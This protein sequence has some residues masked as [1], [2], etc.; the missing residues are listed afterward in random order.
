MGFV[1]FGGVITGPLET[2][3]KTGKC[4]IRLVPEAA[5]KRQQIVVS[6]TRNLI[7][8]EIHIKI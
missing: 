7:S 4:F 5:H 1:V 3:V 6:L 2:L 8:V